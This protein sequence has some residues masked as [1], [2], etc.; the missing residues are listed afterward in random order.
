MIRWE[1]VWFLQFRG[2]KSAAVP[3]NNGTV[4]TP[5]LA[6]NDEESDVMTTMEKL[7]AEAKDVSPRWHQTLLMPYP[8]YG[9]VLVVVHAS[10]LCCFVLHERVCVSSL[11]VNF[12]SLSLSLSLFF[13]CASVHSFLSSGLTSVHKN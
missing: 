9:T 3:A 13:F 12:L 4:A 1:L 7:E 10:F 5:A 6:S 11:Y 8:C 2:L